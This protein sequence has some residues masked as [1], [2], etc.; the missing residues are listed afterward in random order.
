MTTIALKRLALMLGLAAL[1]VDCWLVSLRCSSSPEIDWSRFAF[2]V[3]LQVA[4]VLIP[5]I[6]L[7]V[8]PDP[9]E[10]PRILAAVVAVFLV[11]AST[12]LLRTSLLLSDTIPNKFFNSPGYQCPGVKFVSTGI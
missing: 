4:A 7:L 2:G 8:F 9:K 11:V 6:A 12:P 3:V 5:F 1:A 10:K